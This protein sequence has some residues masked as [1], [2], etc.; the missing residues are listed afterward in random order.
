MTDCSE[1]RDLLSEYMDHALDA[2]AKALADKH[3]STCAACREELESLKALAQGLGSLPSVKAP[4]D[5]LDQLHRRMERPSTL[6]RMRTWLF[7]P[8]RVK[9]PLQLAGAAVTALIIF[10]ILPLQQSSLKLS[11]KPEQEKKEAAYYTDEAKGMI[12][13]AER[14]QATVPRAAP[15]APEKDTAPG[16]PAVRSEALVQKTPIP[17]P[18]RET[19]EVALHLKRQ[20]HAKAASAE[21]DAAQ[22]PASA[23]VQEMQKHKL[24]AGAPVQEDKKERDPVLS[25]TQAVGA[26]KGRVL[27]VDSSPQTGRPESVN[28]E[29]PAG[30]LPVLYEKLRE[31]G[32]L[33]VSP[34]TG[35]ETDSDLVPVK[36]R[37]IEIQ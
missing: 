1:I 15:A 26:A 6:S 29:M 12:Q 37:L 21:R 27:S 4:A 35:A 13:P 32:D 25:I 18:A 3:L 22:A 31:L 9:I 17:E 20:V 8:L 10:S 30:E 14:P 28:A 7:L 11:T 5:F 24:A 19:R 33:E 16:K 34:P 23:A 2:E 36:I